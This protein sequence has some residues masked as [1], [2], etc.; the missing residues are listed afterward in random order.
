MA[1]AGC[2]NAEDATTAALRMAYFSAD[3]VAAVAGF[4]PECIGDRSLQIRVGLHS[5]PVVA[6]VVGA[7]MPR[8]LYNLIFDYV[9][10][11][12]KI[13]CRIR[14]CLFGDT[15]N[16]AS[17]MESN[18]QAM[19]IHISS[20]TSGLLRDTL[21][22]SSRDNCGTERSSPPDISSNGDETKPGLFLECRGEIPIKGKGI[23]QTYWLND[24]RTFRTDD[25]DSESLE[26]LT[27]FDG[28]MELKKSNN[29]EFAI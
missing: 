14:Y 23:M 13:C 1:V 15:V 5:G 9:L 24:Y 12:M 11:V 19:R 18:S 21:K 7:K 3:V 25:R 2:P 29:E 4:H 28:V 17:R 8:L 26:K 6:G 16:T 27:S 20:A 22:Y 10:V